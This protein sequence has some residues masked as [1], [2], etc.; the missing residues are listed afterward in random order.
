ML[1]EYNGSAPTED[2]VNK[3]FDIMD[4][5]GSGDIS[6]EEAQKYIK[7]YELGATLKNILSSAWKI[8]HVSLLIL[9]EIAQKQTNEFYK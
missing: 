7:G 3:N 8:S 4:I 1:T 2:E 6:K 9:I 5:D